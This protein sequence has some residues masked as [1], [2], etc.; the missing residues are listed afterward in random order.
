MEN[1]GGLFTNIWNGYLVRSDGVIFNK[2]GSE[3]KKKINNKGYYFSNFY[4]GGA[5]HTRSFHRVIAEALIGPC[6]NGYEVDHINNDRKDNRLENLRYLT[7]AENNQKSWDSGNRNIDGNLNPNSLYRKVL[8][9][10]H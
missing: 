4:Y 9:E 6:P 8:R 7:K 10:I 5:S 2:D 1:H 3:K